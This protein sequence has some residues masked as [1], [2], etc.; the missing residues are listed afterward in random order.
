MSF[1]A[2]SLEIQPPENWETM[3]QHEQRVATRCARFLKRI[4]P[5]LEPWGDLLGRWHDLGKYQ[6]E[7]QRKLLGESVQIEH[8]GAGAALAVNKDQQR[9]LPI[10]FAIAG[11]HTGLANAKAN[12]VEYGPVKRRTLAE[13]LKDNLAI[14]DK[15]MT[16]ADSPL[17]EREIPELPN[18]VLDT[19]MPDESRRRSIDF[20]TRILFSALVDADRLATEW[21][22][23]DAEGKAVRQ[24]ELQY[25]SLDSLRKHLDRF[26]D[27]KTEKAKSEPT[28]I[29]DL[30]ARILEECRAATSQLAGIFS[31][32]VP[33]GGGKTLSAMSFALRHA[34]A[35]GMD[36][37]IV[38]IPY[39]SIIR[40]NALVYRVAFGPAEGV[41]DDRNVLEHHSGIDEQKA[42]EENEPAE[43]RRRIAA[44]NWDA[45]IVV[46]TS[47]Q[48]FESL[49]SDH[50]SQCRK[51]H[52]IANS[53]VILDEVQTLPPHFLLPIV[54]VLRELSENYK[55][56]I[57]LSTA[58]PPSLKKY[59]DN[60][61][62][63][64]PD[65]TALSKDP[66][67]RRVK[68][69]W[70]VDVP[71]SYDAIA[72][73]IR[74]EGIEQALVVVHRRK[75][76][77]TLAE[78]LPAEKRIHLS[79]QMCPAHRIERLDEIDRRLEASEPCLVVA[80]QLIEAGVDLDM[81]VVYRALGGVDSLAQ[82][83]GRCDREGKR[84]IAA[85]EPA[86][87]LIV[88]R[89]E[90]DPPGLTL[91]KALA[92]TQTVHKRKQL[93]GETLDIFNPDHCIEFFEEFYAANEL[94]RKHLQRERAS[95]NFANV[96]AAFQMI[97]DGWSFPVVVPWPFIGE[98]KDEGRRRAD[99]FRD[100]PNQ[101]TPRALQ[102]YIVQIPKG[103]AD[104]LEADAIIE[105]WESSIG[106]PTC[107][108]D[109]TFYSSEF[110]IIVEEGMNPNPELLQV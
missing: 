43:I 97:E 91:R 4:H 95:L 94:D 55:T 61:Q 25:D 19:K 64:I 6:D 3:A 53:V 31:L 49:L 107:L 73:E 105:K 37:V 5:D 87:R 62:K 70:R 106:L 86:G 81:P 80:T 16:K 36:R 108:F 83:A 82:A 89:A 40:Q 77:K 1:Y 22:Y 30:R 58:T 99:R 39:T 57:V 103:A 66:A 98:N 23:S 13:R 63:I 84:T 34:L 85:G 101:E 15:I 78:L 26:V 96:A 18:W 59:F 75:D 44:E 9:G 92:A 69:E 24:Q 2:H 12:E 7:F 52:R 45:P 46:T 88:F 68:T 27:A 32:T 76:A 67:A 56:S 21:F 71:V 104:Q 90:T 93:S 50:P 41:L 100:E 29:N 28:P 51:L 11:H 65:P 20:F 47:V 110:G 17:I 109:E 102:P 42:K 48:F 79:A 60:V 8:A 10:A 14:V 72:K 54:D 33:T 74:D 35:N 38:V